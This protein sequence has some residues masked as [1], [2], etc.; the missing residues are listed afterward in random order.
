MTETPPVVK[1][2]LVDQHILLN[3]GLSK[4]C[5]NSIPLGNAAE[6]ALF[7]FVN[8]V[9]FVPL[10]PSPLVGMVRASLPSRAGP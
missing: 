6:Y 7:V 1:R 2:T 9:K 10:T 3:P 5:G 4:I 8:N